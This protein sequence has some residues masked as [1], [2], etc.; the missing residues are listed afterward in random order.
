ML[1]VTYRILAPTVQLRLKQ[2]GNGGDTHSLI[3]GLN[4]LGLQAKKGEAFV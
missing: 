2:N 1:H 3:W 4:N